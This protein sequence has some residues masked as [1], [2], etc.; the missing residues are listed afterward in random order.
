MQQFSPTITVGVLVLYV[1]IG[2]IWKI[3][4]I[5][6]LV[7]QI[8]LGATI[9][10]VFGQALFALPNGDNLPMSDLYGGAD[11][12]GFNKYALG[13]LGT[14]VGILFSLIGTGIGKLVGKR[15]DS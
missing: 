9:Y 3:P 5:A 13:F 4:L 7:L 8:G 10:F 14:V 15:D 12:P 2:L 6:R 11:G 1:V